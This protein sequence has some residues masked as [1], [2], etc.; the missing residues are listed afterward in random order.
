MC[1][2][3]IY[4]V[5]IESSKDFMN[6]IEAGLSLLDIFPVAWYDEEQNTGWLKEY[7]ET[8]YDAQARCEEITPFLLQWS[9]G[10]KYNLSIEK[11]LNADWQNSW[12]SHFNTQ[13]ISERIVIKPTWE[14][15]DPSPDEIVIEMDPGMSFGTGLHPTTRACIRFL[16]EISPQFQNDSFLDL[17]CGSGVLSIAASKLG[18]NHIVAMDLDKLSIEA[19]MENC[20]ANSVDIECI[21]SDLSDFNR[22]ETF[23][24]V[25]ANI[26]CNVLLQFAD[27]I[28]SYC[29]GAGD[30][31][32]LLAGILKEQ[33]P[34]VKS[35]YTEHGLKEVKS[36]DDGEWTSGLFKKD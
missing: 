25:T 18:F 16:E 12:K 10:E 14:T 36:V 1:K 26:L 11:V 22:K 17:G 28:S 13:H 7:F 30:S 34:E 15:Y 20:S 31:Y 33:Y 29:G 6:I 3:Y 21:E 5:R 32:L 35:V 19:T 8:E 2:D 4:E 27:K 9:D 24:I 23:S